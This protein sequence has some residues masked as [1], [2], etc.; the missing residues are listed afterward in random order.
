[1]Q[2]EWVWTDLRADRTAP[3]NCNGSRSR[4][5]SALEY[6]ILGKDLLFESSEVQACPAEAYCLKT[7]EEVPSLLSFSK[8]KEQIEKWNTFWQNELEITYQ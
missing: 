2:P 6:H 8:L 3:T 1:M 7:V 5:F 4:Q